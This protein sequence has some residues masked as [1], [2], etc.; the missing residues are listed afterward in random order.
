MRGD[1][2][3]HPVAVSDEN[4]EAALIFNKYLSKIGPKY[5]IKLNL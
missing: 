1:I 2:S 5:I 3:I 4:R